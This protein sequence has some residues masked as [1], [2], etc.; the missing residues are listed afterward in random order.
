MRCAE[1][2]EEKWEDGDGGLEKGERLRRGGG[3]GKVF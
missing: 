1:R 2:E 3:K